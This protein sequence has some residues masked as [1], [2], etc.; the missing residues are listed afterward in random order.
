MAGVS[1]ISIFSKRK[2]LAPLNVRR[3]VPLKLYG[4]KVLSCNGEG[5]KPYYE[6]DFIIR[7]GQQKTSNF[8]IRCAEAVGDFVVYVTTNQS[9]SF[10]SH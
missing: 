6:P 4:K 3:V 2:A 1:T 8:N 5:T 7:V 10:R 9:S